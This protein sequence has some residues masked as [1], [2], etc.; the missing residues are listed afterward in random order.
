MFYSLS[1]IVIFGL[2]VSLLSQLVQLGASAY[3]LVQPVAITPPAAF[4]PDIPSERGREYDLSALVANPLF[5]APVEQQ[6]AVAPAIT[7]PLRLVG[8]IG[9]RDGIVIIRYQSTERSYVAG[10]LIAT[11]VADFRLNLIDEGYV[12]L[13]SPHGVHR[14]TLEARAP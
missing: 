14:L 13:R 3:S 12:E 8:I 9:G 4:L 2:A 6:P 1:N 10:D 5:K 7:P 11:S